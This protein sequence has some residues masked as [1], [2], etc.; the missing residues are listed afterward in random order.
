LPAEAPLSA[1]E[2]K[3]DKRKGNRERVPSKRAQESSTGK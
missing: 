1:H 2:T 3:A